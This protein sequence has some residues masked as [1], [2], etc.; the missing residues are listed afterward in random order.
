MA[1]KVRHYGR[2]TFQ[3]STNHGGRDDDGRS[4]RY[5]GC[6]TWMTAT[7]NTQWSSLIYY[8]KAIN[9]YGSSMNSIAEPQF[10]DGKPV[11][12]KTTSR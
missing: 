7:P 8:A 6:M 1:V 3:S 2:E 10:K 11:R 9:R 5:L 4:L 12:K